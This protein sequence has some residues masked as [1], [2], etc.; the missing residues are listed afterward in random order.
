MGKRATLYEWLQIEEIKENLF[1]AVEDRRNDEFLDHLYLYLS[2]AVDK[3][4]DW[5]DIP[6]IKLRDLFV[7]TEEANAPTKPFPILFSRKDNK[8]GW[9]YVGRTW[10]FWLNI[11]AYNYGWKIEYIKQLDI[12][13][14]IAL[15]QEILLDEQ[16]NRDFI[17]STA[18]VAYEYNANTKKSKFNALDK[19]DWM[20]IG[21]SIDKE[22][23]NEKKIKIRRDFLP[24]GRIVSWNRK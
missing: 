16:R 7:E 1:S 6:W 13:D 18:E 19:P 14:A 2:T 3:E 9:G 20:G 8:P 17:W 12:D 21:F 15:L 4:K 22:E 24:V 10:Y 11:F 23:P 5:S